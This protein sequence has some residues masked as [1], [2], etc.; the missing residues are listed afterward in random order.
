MHRPPLNT[1]PTPQAMNINGR[2]SYPKTSHPIK[3]GAKNV[4]VAPPNTAA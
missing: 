2:I 3:T 1:Y 4:L